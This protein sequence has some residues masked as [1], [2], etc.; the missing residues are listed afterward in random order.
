MG[1]GRAEALAYMVCLDSKHLDFDLYFSPNLC[2]KGGWVE[3]LEH[4]TPLLSIHGRSSGL[5][6]AHLSVL[7]DNFCGLTGNRD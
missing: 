7:V 6:V 3:T 5:A 4:L 1:S 2:R